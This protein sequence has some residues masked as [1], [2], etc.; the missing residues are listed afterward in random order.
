LY[1]L[2]LITEIA[3]FTRKRA[4]L[5]MRPAVREVYERLIQRPYG[6]IL[7]SGPTGSGKTT[8]LASTM[9]RLNSGEQ[10]IS[11]HRGSYRVPDQRG[12]PGTRPKAV[13]GFW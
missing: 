5:G 9:I 8:T 12:E 6:L 11:H 13:S 1:R 3:Y 2:D 7:V 4:K 10:N